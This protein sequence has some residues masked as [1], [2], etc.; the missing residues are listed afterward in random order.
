LTLDK[1]VPDLPYVLRPKALRPT[2]TALLAA[3]AILAVPAAAQAA[4]A[5]TPTTKAFAAFGDSA[6]YSL[7]PNGAF[8]T[9]A[10]GWSLTGA[11]VANGSESFAVHAP[12]DSKSLAIAAT[13][14]AVSPAICVD[15]DHP[16]FRFF[17]RRTSGSWGVLNVKLRW[18][19]ANGST[20]ETVVGSLGTGTAW[21]PSSVLSL[22]RSLPLWSAGQTA[23][24]QLVFDPEDFG[25]AWAIDDVYVDPYVRG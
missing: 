8:E 15:I 25:G 22:G 10:G 18:K 17:A 14:V 7:A 4:C 20:N 12:G 13:G 1:E 9:G 24:V 23:T 11:S 5:T 6:D 19:D 3:A 16:T 2:V 21:Q